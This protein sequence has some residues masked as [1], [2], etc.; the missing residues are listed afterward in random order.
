[1][2]RI[3]QQEVRIRSDHDRDYD[4]DPY[5]YSAPSYRYHRC[6]RYY[7]TNQYGADLLR[8]AVNYGYEQGFRAGEADRQDRWHSNNRGS[9]GPSGRELWLHGI[10][11]DQDEYN[12]YFRQGFRHGY[13]DGFNGRYQYGHI[14]TARIPCLRSPSG[15]SSA[16][17]R[18]AEVGGLTRALP[19][20]PQQVCAAGR[21]SE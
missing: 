15:R 3:R 7:E 13:E 12:Y 16:S 11:V 4:R 21:A 10:Y 8:Q 5:F 9:F 1:M 14:Q 18:F 17:S 20:D 6:D 19:I 2:E